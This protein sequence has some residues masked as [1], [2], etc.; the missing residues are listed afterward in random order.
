MNKY[1]KAMKSFAVTVPVKYSQIFVKYQCHN[2]HTPIFR[3]TT[4]SRYYTPKRYEHTWHN[5]SE[6]DGAVWP[7]LCKSFKITSA[8]VRP[9]S[10]P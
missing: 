8:A 1:Q 10:P 3:S 7:E 4:R 6:R 2:N 9:Y 5:I